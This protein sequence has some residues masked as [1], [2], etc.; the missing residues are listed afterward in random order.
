VKPCS[1]LR[2]YVLDR[3]I[4]A[5]EERLAQGGLTRAKRREHCANLKTL[6]KWQT[7]EVRRIWMCSGAS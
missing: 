7:Q 1:P 5:V 4:R 3:G 2:L 6:K